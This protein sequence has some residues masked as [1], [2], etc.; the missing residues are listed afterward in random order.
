M[1]E[2]DLKIKDCEYHVGEVNLINWK[3][4][5]KYNK[6]RN[7]KYIYVRSVQVQITPLQYY[8]KDID[9][10]AP[11]CDIRHTK[12]NNQIITRMKT[13][14]CNGLVGFNCRPGCY[15]S[16][17]GEFTTNFLPFKIKQLEWT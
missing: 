10:Y 17:K 1:M 4:I 16:L 7:C 14:L 11:L 12:F 3:N 13:N 2:G 5:L 9:P 6:D 8:D 15:L